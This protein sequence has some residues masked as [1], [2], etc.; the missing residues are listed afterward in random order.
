MNS[1][2]P[3]ARSAHTHYHISGRRARRQELLLKSL[4][5]EAFF[6]EP[7]LLVVTCELMDRRLYCR[8][9]IPA[10]RAFT[11]TTT[12]LSTE[13]YIRPPSSVTP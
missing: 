13:L 2:G 11:T 10:A 9:I 3:R 5:I 6:T 1:Y 4:K 12:M 8:A 7:A